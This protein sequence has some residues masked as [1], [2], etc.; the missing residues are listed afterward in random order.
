MAYSKYIKW[1]LMIVGAMRFKMFGAFLGFFLGLFIEELIDGK[2]SL[3]S[4][5]PTNDHENEL[6]LSPYQEKLIRLIAA[7][8]KDQTVI[9]RAESHYILKYFY[10]QFGTKKGKFLFQ[11]LKKLVSVHVDYVPSAKGLSNLQRDGKIQVIKFLFGLTQVVSSSNRGQANVMENIA[12]NIGINKQDFDRIKQT[13][14]SSKRNFVEFF[15]TSNIE[16]YYKVLGV[17][18][19]VSAEE[20]KKA[21]RKLV[22]KYHPDKTELSKELAT[23]KFQE[24]QEAYDSLRSNMGIK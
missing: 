19:G 23:R 16:R 21:Y 3:F 6:V 8:L 13:G 2:S 7:L 11:A 15:Q 17:Q 14:K 22:L 24:V 10:R 18:K 5:G 12:K 9:S 1:V 20:L 4:R